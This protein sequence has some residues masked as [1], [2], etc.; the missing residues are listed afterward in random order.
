M[1]I[2]ANV[3]VFLLGLFIGD[4]IAEIIVQKKITKLKKELNEKLRRIDNE[5]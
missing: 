2:L 3:L 1:K 4:C 5:C